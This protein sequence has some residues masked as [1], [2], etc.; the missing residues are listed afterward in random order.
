MK[1]TATQL[2]GAGIKRSFSWVDIVVLFGVFGLLWTMLHF[3]QGMV[4][5]F[6]ENRSPAI[7]T[8]IRNI[9]Y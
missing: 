7:S 3:G 1:S 6:D 5:H 2:G 8:D 4:I 9:P